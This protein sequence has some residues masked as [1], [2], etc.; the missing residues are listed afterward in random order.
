MFIETDN[1]INRE[2]IDTASM[3]QRGQRY[4]CE[5]MQDIPIQLFANK[6]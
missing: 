4:I 6:D 5:N 3:K 2:R 1:H